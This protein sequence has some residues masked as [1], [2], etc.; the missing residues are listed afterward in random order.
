VA[1]AGFARIVE[2]AGVARLQGHPHVLRHACGYAFAN[3]GHD[4]RA[5]QT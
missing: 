4:T 1:R 3:K 2:R 5:L